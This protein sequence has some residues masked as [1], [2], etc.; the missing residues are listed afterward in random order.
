[1]DQA[2]R[3]NRRQ[4][5]GAFA[6]GAAVGMPIALP[7]LAALERQALAGTGPDAR[8]RAGGSVPS[9]FDVRRFGAAADGRKPATQAFQQAIDAAAA[10]GGGLVMVPPGR[11]LCGALF[12][13]SNIHVHVSAGA[14]LLASDRPED[15]PP[16]PGRWEGIERKTHSSLFTGVE[17]EN[18]AITGFGVLEGQGPSWWKANVATVNMR[19]E[20]GLPREA[21]NPPGAPLR[22]PRPR[23]INL[24][25]AQGIVISGLTIRDGPS[26]NVHLV[27]CHDVVLDGVTLQALEAQNCDGIVIDSCKQVR[28]ANCSVT[29]GSDCISLKSGYNEDGRRV[30]LPCEDITISNCSMSMSHSAAVAIGSESSGGVK[31]VSI[32]NCVVTGCEL[33]FYIKSPRGR[34]GIIERFRASNVVLDPLAGPAILVTNFFDSVRLDFG[35][36]RGKVPPK[37][38]HETDRAS[39]PPV[40]EGT[41]TIRELEFT[42]LTLGE[43]AELAVIEGLPE[44][45]IQ[46]LSIRD[47]AAGRA[48]AG[49]SCTR[50]SDV[51]LSGITLNPVESP[52]VSARDVERLEIHRLRCARPNARAPL[53][54]LE[55]VAGAFIHGCDANVGNDR[56]AFVRQKGDKNRAVVVANNNIGK[57]G[58][59]PRG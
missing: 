25:R 51:S 53:V 17:V 41:P 29:T 27:Y 34:G 31:N 3:R 43:V 32:A 42:G 23:V 54:Q 15:F 20:R 7:A 9:L 45:Y 47:V 46:G 5:M 22:W 11:Y 35:Y 1:M 14:T 24:I 4:F 38:T 55:N 18:V 12:L 6:G 39:K 21:D 2:N 57:G 16:I 50:A 44:R 40:T 49:V 10:V 36:Y 48:K 33:G 28:I 56:D 30:G 19:V 8:G 52:A 58:G 37:V 13:R 26:W 59:G